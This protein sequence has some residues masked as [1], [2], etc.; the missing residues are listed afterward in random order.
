MLLPRGAPIPAGL[1][2]RFQEMWNAL[3]LGGGVGYTAYGGNWGKPPADAMAYP[4]RSFN[5]DIGFNPIWYNAS[6]DAEIIGRVSAMYGQY[7]RPLNYNVYCNYPDTDLPDFALNYWAGNLPRL[8]E[9]KGRYDPLNVFSY[10]Q[11]I[12][13]PAP[14]AP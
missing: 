9:I 3:D 6:R 11:S 2:V 12:P 13:L 5:G 8:R 4:H 14:A 1:F 10:P 7:V